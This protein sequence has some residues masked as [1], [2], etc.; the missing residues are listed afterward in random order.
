M[1]D[2]ERHSTQASPDDRPRLHIYYL[3]RHFAQSGRTGRDATV[4]PGPQSGAR[5]DDLPASPLQPVGALGPLRPGGERPAPVPLRRK[6]LAH[7]AGVRGRDE[8]TGAAE[9]ANVDGRATMD[10]AGLTKLGEGVDVEGLGRRVGYRSPNRLFFGRC[11]RAAACRHR[12]HNTPAAP[13]GIGLNACDLLSLDVQEAGYYLNRSDSAGCEL[14]IGT[15]A[16][17]PA[18]EPGGEVYLSMVRHRRTSPQCGALG[19]ATGFRARCPA[20]DGVK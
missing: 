15:V 12:S 3:P 10:E 20:A 2:G 14:R 19:A 6:R 4:A 18:T 5:V 1:S 7:A 13:K 9:P 8:P 17:S 11:N 16:R